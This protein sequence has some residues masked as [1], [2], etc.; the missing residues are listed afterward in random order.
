MDRDRLIKQLAELRA[1]AHDVWEQA[2]GCGKC[3][4]TG[5]TD[6]AKK[7]RCSA[8]ARRQLGVDPAITEAELKKRREV[9]VYASPPA[10]DVPR[11]P[12]HNDGYQLPWKR[13]PWMGPRLPTLPRPRRGH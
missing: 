4:G 6:T 8:A 11:L 9:V 13:R 7:C 10:T 5:T 12:P 3:L 1:V 2:G